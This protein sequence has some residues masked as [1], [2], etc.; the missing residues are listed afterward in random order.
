[1]SDTSSLKS[2]VMESLNKI[3]KSASDTLCDIVSEQDHKYLTHNELQDAYMA[4]KIIHMAHE[5]KMSM[6]N[7]R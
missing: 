6:S 5:T 4:T 7:T 3:C 1:M 2:E